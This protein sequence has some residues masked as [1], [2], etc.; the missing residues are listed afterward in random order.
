MKYLSLI[1]ALFFGGVVACEGTVEFGENQAVAVVSDVVAPDGKADTIDGPAGL[2][3]G[4]LFSQYCAACHG[5]DATGGSSYPQSIVGYAPIDDIVQNGI[6]AMPPIAID[7]EQ[8]AAIQTFLLGDT[9]SAEPAVNDGSTPALQVYTTQCSGCHGAE[10]L[11]TPQG[12]SLRFRDPGLFRFAVRDGRNGPGNP[13][14]MPVYDHSLVTDAQLDEVIEWLDA[15]PNPTDGEG[16]YNRYCANCHG[17]DGRGGPSFE[18]VAGRQ[19]AQSIIREGHALGRYAER[20]E[21]MPAWTA[22]QISDQ[23]IVAIEQYMAQM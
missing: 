14:A 12:P 19:R 4:A 13:S 16:L 15:F 10:G 8:T 23:E 1:F 6:G 20:R 9:S 7:A 18:T 21:Y 2:D 5:A 17:V 22:E 3:G 11:G